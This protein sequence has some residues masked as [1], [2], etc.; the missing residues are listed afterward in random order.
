ML[1]T[2]RE[3]A[4]ALRDQPEVRA[5]VPMLPELKITPRF[6]ELL[7]KAPEVTIAL[8]VR[9]VPLA[10]HEDLRR[11]VAELSTALTEA[12][13]AACATRDEWRKLHACASASGTGVRVRAE[14]E[15][16]LVVEGLMRAEALDVAHFVVES[17]P[18][19]YW[20]EPHAEYR[21]LNSDGVTL[22]QSGTEGVGATTP[23][24]DMGIH[25][26]GEVIG[27]G[28]SGL[29]VGHCFFEDAPGYT[30]RCTCTRTCTCTCPCTCP[31]TCICTCMDV[32]RCFFAT[33]RATR[34][35]YTTRR[36]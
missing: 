24:W 32:G 21:Q 15:R 36:T 18:E 5:V 22:T 4:A 16:A 35:A 23:I 8:N 27:V 12:L 6:D 9:L 29:D 25:G 3:G 33:R 7:P 30:R 19:A 2:T 11:P 1:H 10:R 14:S 20:V 26:E 34:P 28:D 31:C 13:A 17:L